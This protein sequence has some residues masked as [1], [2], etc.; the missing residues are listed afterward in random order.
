MHEMNNIERFSFFRTY[1]VAIEKFKYKDSKAEF[2]LAILDYVFYDKE[3]IFTKK[4]KALKEMAW[5]SIEAN[6]KSSKNKANNAKKKSEESQ[7]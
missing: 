2:T 7:T 4:E 3:P 5:V 1:F 6:L